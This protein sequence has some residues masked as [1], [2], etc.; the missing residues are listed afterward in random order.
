MDVPVSELTPRD[1]KDV[2]YFVVHHAVQDPTTDIAQLAQEEETSQGFITIGY[3]AYIKKIA[4]GHW[5]IQEG[6]PLDT[7]P[8]AAYGVNETSYDVCIGGNYEPNVSG[9]PTNQVD[10][11]SLDVL[12]ARIEEVKTKCPNMKYLIGHRDVAPIMVKHGGNSGDYSTAC[13]GDLLYAELHNLR[14]KTG[15]ATPP[16]LL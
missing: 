12:V 6:R 15:L 7:L 10:P 4:E 11:A 16:E 8:A 9:V 14:V 5:E 3:N 13:P 1:P 2:I